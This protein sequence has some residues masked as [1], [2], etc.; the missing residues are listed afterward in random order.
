M[1]AH[2]LLA[3]LLLGATIP[4]LLFL[5]AAAAG[6][7]VIVQLLEALKWERHSQEV[8]SKSLEQRRTLEGLRLCGLALQS[9]PPPRPRSDLVAEF[10]HE[11]AA[12][13]ARC[14]ELA[15]LVADHDGQQQ[16]IAR[17]RELETAWVAAVAPNIRADA[18]P[19]PADALLFFRSGEPTLGELESSIDEF[20]AVEKRLFNDRHEIV[21]RQTRRS[22]WV[23][24]CAFGLAAL[25]SPLL[26][27]ASAR[28]IAGPVRRLYRATAD[29]VAGRFRGLQPEGPA[30]IE[31]LILY[32]NHMAVTLT[33][34]TDL[35]LEQ[36]ARYRSYI[37]AVTQVLWVTD[38]DGALT[39]PP[40]CLRELTCL[41]A[42]A[43][44][45]S[46]WLDAVHPEDRVRVEGGWRDALRRHALFEAECRLCVRDGECRHVLL[47]CVP[48]IDANGQV[49]EWAC[50][51]T[52]VTERVRHAELLRAKE[53]AE[54]TSR[55]KSEF[56]TR[57]SHELRT[58]LNAVIG[59]S[60][61]LTTQ[62]LGALTAR[63]ADYLNDITHAGEHLLELINEIL[64]LA[65][66]E[67]G[68]MDVRPEAMA[69][70]PVLEAV[71]STL[72]P[73]ARNKGVELSL[74]APAPGAVA[75]DPSRF[76]QILYNL[77]SNAIKFTPGGGKVTVSAEWLS[78]AER[79]AAP[80]PEPEATAVRVRVRDTGIGIAPE[81]Q[82]VIWEEFK[83]ASTTPQNQGTGLGLA[84][85]RRLVGLLGGDVWL[86]STPGEG[87]TF[88][89]VLPRPVPQAT[90]ENRPA[91]E[92]AANVAHH[93]HH[94]RHAISALVLDVNQ[95]PFDG[96]QML[97]TH[98]EQVGDLSKKDDGCQ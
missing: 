17:F 2:S 88:S 74:E 71:R 69:L 67:S 57:M 26:A 33:G 24:T 38:A 64:D 21:T 1:R 96:C 19:Q 78:T 91:D 15:D 60:K 46:G 10:R 84:L 50:S 20:I 4:L 62:R 30:E 56:L 5:A 35:L 43:L 47:R 25:L 22:F 98:V 77:L 34:R 75:T 48:V 8:I 14:S 31:R 36:E 85:T 93:L 81:E 13:Q 90:V 55:A 45:G 16:R 6:A 51:G 49:R 92:V 59:M 54:A 39:D 80:V 42:E 79:E 28:Q 83:Q 70:V 63:Q 68:R 86:Q 9:S 23:L 87:S 44:Q 72:R 3:R 40:P 94:L 52:D 7:V 82:E 32:F 37:G 41:G 61:M 12:F 95:P 65:K 11:H 18:V 66:L 97:T 76:R 73:L 29:L 58:P 89:F 53:E 27:Y